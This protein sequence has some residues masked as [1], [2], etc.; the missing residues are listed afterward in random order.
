MIVVNNGPKKGLGQTDKRIQ[1]I[2]NMAK[3][4]SYEKN[5]YLRMAGIPGIEGIWQGHLALLD[6]DP[7]HN[8]AED[9]IANFEETTECKGHTIKTT[10]AK[11]GKF[12]V[13]NN[14]N[15]FSKTYTARK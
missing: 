9:M 10:V 2:V 14:R 5:S 1:P 3:P 13:T 11:D 8:T 12:T 4:A 15:G 7:A 6:K